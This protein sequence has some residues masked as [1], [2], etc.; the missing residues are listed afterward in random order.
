MT[1]LPEV[2]LWLILKSAANNLFTTQLIARFCPKL[3]EDFQSENKKKAFQL[4]TQGLKCPFIF[5]CIE[6]SDRAGV[7]D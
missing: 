5:V 1:Q 6:G 4:V 7:L 3:F 2:L